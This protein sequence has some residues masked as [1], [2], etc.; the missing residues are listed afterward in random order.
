MEDACTASTCSLTVNGDV[1]DTSSH[2]GNGNQDRYIAYDPGSISNDDCGRDN[3]LGTAASNGDEDN[4]AYD[5]GSVSVKD[6]NSS[7]DNSLTYDPGGVNFSGDIISGL[8]CDISTRLNCNN[9]GGRINTK[10]GCSDDR[11]T[12]NDLDHSS[13]IDNNIVYD[14]ASIRDNKHGHDTGLGTTAC[15]NNCYVVYDP[16]GI[17]RDDISVD[18]DSLDFGNCKFVYDPGSKGSI[19][20]AQANPVCNN[21]KSSGY[22][23]RK[24]NS[25]ISRLCYF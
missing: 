6:N 3:G 1:E 13:S 15:N 25:K 10:T 16:G 9:C 19:S 14:P 2:D 20:S 12:V 5:P 21:N 23:L 8:P 7:I 22:R 18:A 4:I 24:L 11:D 17:S